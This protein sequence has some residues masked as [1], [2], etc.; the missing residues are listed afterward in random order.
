M[1]PKLI[2]QTFRPTE[3]G[4]QSWLWVD[5][6]KQK[7]SITDKNHRRIVTRGLDGK[8]IEVDHNGKIIDLV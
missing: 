3:K 5:C 2:Y 4:S 8:L 1:K 6:H 7:Y